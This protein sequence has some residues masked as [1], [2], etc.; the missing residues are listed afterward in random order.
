MRTALIT[1]ANRG[2]GLE[3]ARQL[4]DEGFRLVL[5]CRDLKAADTVK[6]DAGAPVARWEFLDFDDLASIGR[7][8][9]RLDDDGIEIDVLVNNAGVRWIE[10]PYT[11]SA[12]VVAQTFQVNVI[13]PWLLSQSLIPGMVERGRGR[14][15]NVSSMAGS[16][17]TG[18]APSHAAYSVSKAALNAMT[19]NFARVTDACVKINA[20]CPGHIATRMGEMGGVAAPRTVRQGADTAVWLATLDDDGPTGGF[21]KDREPVP[22]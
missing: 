8:L 18:A 6:A 1:G 10:D 7:L 20:T 12:E 15:V 13:G 4:G 2:L 16:M 17:T 9:K 22:W 21:F 5:T 11:T 3:I 19:V 14:V